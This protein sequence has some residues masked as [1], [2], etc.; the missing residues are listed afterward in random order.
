M[1]TRFF[2][3]DAGAAPALPSAVPG[4]IAVTDVALQRA[5][6][7][8]RVTPDDLGAVA[9]HRETCMAACPALVDAFYEKITGFADT[10]S[11]LVQ[12]TTIERQRPLVT[13]YVQQLFT[14]R[15]DDAWVQVRRHVGAVHDRIDL[16]SRWFVAMYEVIHTRCIGAVEARASAADAARFRAAFGRLLQADMAIVVTALTEARTGRMEA[17]RDRTRDFLG[18]VRRAI[19]AVGDGD[20]TARIAGTFEGEYDETR[21]DFNAALDALMQVL[22]QVDLASR[23][24]GAGSAAI[25]HGADALAGDAGRQAA[26][27]EQV[28]ASLA[29]LS[30][31]ARDNASSAARGRLLADGAATAARGGDA[32]AGRLRE[33]LARLGTSAQRTA[34]IVRTIDEIAFQTNLLALNAAVEAARAGDAGRGFAVVAEEVRALARRSA[35]AARET[36]ARI[37]EAVEQTATSAAIG[38]DVLDA[39]GAITAQ[40]H[41]LRTAMLQVAEASAAQTEG[42]QQISVAVTDISDVTQRTAANAEESAA[43]GTELGAQA[44]RLRELVEGF[45]LPPSRAL[46]QLE[47]DAPPA[48][49]RLG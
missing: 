7:F 4:T 34:A 37:S 1:L 11:I 30:A 35:D 19:R 43:A 14:G 23:E 39:F 15:L 2:R 44:S 27:L 18:V 48:R 46:L 8:L 41:D 5:L 25:G 17:E 9:L 21:R 10:R 42:V 32:D 3:P 13:R 49:R 6:E 31:S 47:R 45:S 12:H 16:D 40:V 22:Q 33:A 26:A 20:M 29:A 28:G 36:A 38:Q 24:V